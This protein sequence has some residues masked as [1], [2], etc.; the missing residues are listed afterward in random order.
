MADL[1]IFSATIAADQTVSAPV[2]IGFKTIVG[3]V[4]PAVWS[5]GNQH[6]GCRDV[7]R[8]RSEAVRRGERIRGW[9]AP[10]RRQPM[11]SVRPLKNFSKR[12][13]RSSIWLRWEADRKAASGPKAKIE[14]REATSCGCQDSG[15]MTM[16][17]DSIALPDSRKHRAWPP[18]DNG[19]SI[20]SIAPSYNVNP[21]TIS[22]L[23]A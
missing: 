17:T 8:S 10:P 16:A 19:E 7:H 6:A 18:I 11:R 12:S 22:R 20:R 14:S 2:G 5:S 1:E 15:V 13:P 4:I 23:K 21:S 9:Y 3:F